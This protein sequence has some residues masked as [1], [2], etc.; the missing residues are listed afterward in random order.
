MLCRSSSLCFAVFNGTWIEAAFA[1]IAGSIVAFLSIASKVAPKFSGLYEFTSAVLV[2]IVTRLLQYATRGV[3]CTDALKIQLAG[4]AVLLPGYALTYG[5]T[6]VTTK[7]YICGVIRSVVSV[8][9]ATLLGLGLSLG[10]TLM[11]AI[12]PSYEFISCN[13]PATPSK[14]WLILILPLLIA[15]LHIYF[16][17]P[18][19]HGVAN[20]IASAFALLTFTALDVILP[21][22]GLNSI[23][24]PSAAAS[25]IV[26]VVGNLYARLT[27]DIALG[28][29]VCGILA[30][31]P[32]GIGVS[33]FVTEVGFGFVLRMVCISFSVSLGLLVASLIV[34]PLKQIKRHYMTY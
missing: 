9:T 20:A 28:P 34:F 26:G 3:H 18:L 12:F 6:E 5:I 22:T 13:E 19:K 33:G 16:T 27:G 25:M 11:K 23:Q 29:I 4:L 21:S 2:S 32:G 31:V 7:N 1:F 14:F 24:I 17:A 15:S 10:D 30:L 8:F